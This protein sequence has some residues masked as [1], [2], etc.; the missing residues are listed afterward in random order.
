MQIK[1]KLKTY[2]KCYNINQSPLYKLSSK[3]ELCEL[4]N[5]SKTE[6]QELI[7]SENISKHY[8]CFFIDDRLIQHPINKMYEIHHVI[9]SFLAR[10]ETPAYLHSK[11][12]SSYITNASFHSISRQVMTFDISS[13]FSSITSDT[14]K[15]FFRNKMKCSPDV[16]YILSELCSVKGTLPTGSAVSFYLSFLANID[17]FEEMSILARN[18][19][20]KFTVYVDDI[21]LSGK[22]VDKSLLNTM[23][24]IIEKY[25]YS[26]KNEKTKRYTCNE[27]PIITGLAV[28][29]GKVN[30]VNKFMHELRNKNEFLSGD[31]QDLDN[32]VLLKEYNSLRGKNT[33]LRSL[34]SLIPSLSLEIEEKLRNIIS[35]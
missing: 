3:K 5:V 1:R 4:L 18:N 33:Y 12:K 10:I 20:T 8:D 14:V 6:I 16:A 25:N 13:F 2:N 11:K 29:N 9:G 32:K 22:H 30:S 23:K 17:M 31:I 7:N 19:H 35:V 27:T 21:T 28:S 15:R 34:G 26:I 24:K